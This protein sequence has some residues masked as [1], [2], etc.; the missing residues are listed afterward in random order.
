MT[1]EEIARVAHEVN[2]G[3]CESLGDQSQPVWE[4]A[5]DWQK[6]SAMNGVELHSNG[7]VGP[8]A[9][10]ENWMAEK[11]KGGWTY[12]PE[13]NLVAKTHPCF[14]PFGDLPAEQKSKDHIFRAVV[15]ALRSNGATSKER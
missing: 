8:E 13:K 10:H 4:E 5:P 11:A 2:R 14:L 12:G 6:T 7:D 3:Y 15:H 9:S 1:N